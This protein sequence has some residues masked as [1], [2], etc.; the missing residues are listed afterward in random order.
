VIRAAVIGLGVGERHIAGYD[1]HPECEVVAICDIDADKLQDV[2]S[3][4]PG[5]RATADARE[6][7]ADPDIDVV[8]I[9][10]YDDAHFGQIKLA[11]ETGKHLFV[12]KPLVLYEEEAR[13]VAAMLRERPELKV[14][15]NVP[16][17]FSPRFAEIRAMIAAGGLGRLFAL[18]GDYDY[19]RREKITEGWRGR[20]PYYSVVLGGAIHM[21]DLLR[22]M[23]GLEIT[24]VVSATGNQI[25]TAGTGFKHPDFVTA[26]LRAEGDVVMKVNANLGCVSPHF[27]A[28][29][30]YGT[31]G[32]FVNGLPDGVIYRP[33]AEPVT[34]AYPGVE[35]GDLIPSFVE[36]IVSGSEPA[37][38][39]EDVFATLSVCMAIERAL[40]DGGP[41]A[42]EP[43]L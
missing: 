25:A 14:S 34:S 4:H 39:R 21:V 42:V 16:L 43:L 17:R 33:E 35:K 37:V 31:E 11:L 27:H 12:E 15:T 10:S 26:T 38:T 19:G 5:L 22:W 40:R 3:R 29:R 24:E 2:A 23:S 32:T 8:S 18:E 9:A 6:L 36:S 30:I 1:A 28:V 20:I 7:L 41:V 13:E